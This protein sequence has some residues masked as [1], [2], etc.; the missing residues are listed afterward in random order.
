MVTL[1]EITYIKTISKT[2]NVKMYNFLQSLSFQV[3]IVL[4]ASYDV[5]VSKLE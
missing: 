5:M 2:L 4:A 3:S 1:V